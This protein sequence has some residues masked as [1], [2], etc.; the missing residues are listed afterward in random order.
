MRAGLYEVS[1]VT[2]QTMLQTYTV[3]FLRVTGVASDR[4]GITQRR[5]GLPIYFPITMET[6]LL[7]KQKSNIG[8]RNTLTSL[9]LDFLP[10]AFSLSLCAFFI[11]FF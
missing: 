1:V 7:Y 2:L 5:A 11:L 4:N 9:F 6:R 3:L 8:T 10:V